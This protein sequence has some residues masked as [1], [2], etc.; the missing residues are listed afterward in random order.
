MHATGLVEEENKCEK[1]HAQTLR[2]NM[3]EKI[4]K[5]KDWEMPKNLYR[6]TSSLVQVSKFQIQVANNSYLGESYLSC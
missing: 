6:A 5:S 2:L 4:A 1:E 3:E